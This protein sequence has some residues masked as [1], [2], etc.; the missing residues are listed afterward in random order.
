FSQGT[1]LAAAPGEPPMNNSIALPRPDFL[2]SMP[3]RAMGLDEVLRLA[4][5]QNPRVGIAEQQVREARA[6]RSL[7]QAQLLP[8]LNVA[9]GLARLLPNIATVAG[10]PTGRAKLY[11]APGKA[12]YDLRAS[13]EDLKA[14]TAGQ[15]AATADILTLAA[16][17]YY[18][19]VRA[20]AYVHIAD[21]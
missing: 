6:N 13:R 1:P 15:Q 12:L 17:Q 20:A 7:A 9:A 2:K 3:T 16:E 5:T 11:L 19:L 14:A 4:R 18:E 8:D 10:V 21:Q